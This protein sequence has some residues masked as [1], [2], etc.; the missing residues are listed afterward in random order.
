MSPVHVGDEDSREEKPREQVSEVKHSWLC[1]GT[2]R[3]PA[4]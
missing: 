1:E 3:N 2:V 4:G